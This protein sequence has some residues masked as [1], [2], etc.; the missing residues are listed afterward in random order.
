VVDEAATTTSMTRTH[1]RA[2]PGERVHDAIPLDHWRIKTVAAAVRLGE[3]VTAALAYDGPT[4]AAA[5]ESFVCE[6]LAPTLRPGD[7]VIWDN[8]QPHKAATARAG[9]EARGARV[10][11]LPPYSPDYSPI[12]PGWSKVK[13]ILRSIGARDDQAL[14]DAIGDALRSVTPE[15]VRGYFE[16]C[17]YVVH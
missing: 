15:D 1:G 3:G 13:Q 2:P 11:F 10:L 6:T 17:G 7:V 14:I 8:L 4:D 16:H 12:E 9:V 5:F